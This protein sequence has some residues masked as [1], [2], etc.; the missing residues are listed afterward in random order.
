MSGLLSLEEFRRIRDENAVREIEARGIE[1]RR[2][3]DLLWAQ[4]QEL[5]KSKQET[6]DS[7]ERKQI[8]EEIKALAWKWQQ[9]DAPLPHMRAHWQA[10]TDR[11]SGKVS[12]PRQPSIIPLFEKDEDID[13]ANG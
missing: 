13:H 7:Y 2:Q 8:D 3:A 5:V 1:Y 11:L 10:A 12:P 6:A 9:Y 4:I